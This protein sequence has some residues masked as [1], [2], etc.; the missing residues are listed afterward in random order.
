MKL[1]LASR[2]PR[3]SELLLAAGFEFTVRNADVDETPLP[4][5][6]PR[7]CVRRLAEM[8]ARAVAGGSDEMI[9]GA[10]TIVVADGKMMGK[11]GSPAEAVSML[12]RLSGKRHD[13]MTGVCLL[14]AGILL[15]D[16]ASTAVWFAPLRENEIED[17]VASGEPGDKAG[18]YAIQG[19]G[20]RFIERIDGSY[21]NVVGLPVAMIYAWLRVHFS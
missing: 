3:R 1:I 21:S 20:A 2:S 15:V 16:V 9:L 8:K 4:G 11:P 7:D 13:V 17:Y 19:V 14:G 5:E 18:A 12:R 6:T 10:D